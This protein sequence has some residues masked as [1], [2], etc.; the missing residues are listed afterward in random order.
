MVR[1]ASA[2]DLARGTPRR[3]EG[4]IGA[5]H[6]YRAPSLRLEVAVARGVWCVVNVCRVRVCGRGRAVDHRQSL[7]RGRPTGGSRRS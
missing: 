1:A 3:A 5:Q 4:T 2:R 7:S 6:D